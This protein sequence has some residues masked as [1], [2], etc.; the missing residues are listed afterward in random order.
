[1]NFVI[2]IKGIFEE[3]QCIVPLGSGNYHD[4]TAMATRQN[5]VYVSLNYRVGAFGMYTQ[6]I[7]LT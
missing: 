2:L 1:M 5:V 7:M 3:D 6:I 4:G